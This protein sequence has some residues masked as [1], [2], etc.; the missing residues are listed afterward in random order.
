MM[1]LTWLL[2]VGAAHG[3]LPG[4]VPPEASVQVARLVVELG[5]TDAARQ[6]AAEEALLALGPDASGPLV[7]CVRGAPPARLRAIE[8]LLPRF[9]PAAV[10]RLVW[11]SERDYGHERE[12]VNAAI[13][14]VGRMGPPAIPALRA[15]LNRGHGIGFATQALGAMGPPG[16][17]EL[18]G[19]VSGPAPQVRARAL[20]ALASYPEA[21]SVPVFLTALESPDPE[22]RLQGLRGLGSL[23]LPAT[24]DAIG[25]RLADEN[26]GVREWAAAVVVKVLTPPLR[27]KLIE[28][29][30]DD[31]SVLV[32]KSAARGLM[33]V[34]GDP[35]AVRLG[36]RY[37]PRTT[38]EPETGGPRLAVALRLMLGGLLLYAAVWLGARRQTGAMG[39][40]DAPKAATAVALMGFYWGRLA[41]GV[42]GDVER[43]LLWICVPAVAWVLWFAGP[44]LRALLLPAAGLAASLAI[45]VVAPAL[46][47]IFTLW[48]FASAPAWLATALASGLAA[49]VWAGRDADP[50]ALRAFRRAAI[51]SLGA[52]YLGYSVGWWALW[53]LR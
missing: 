19:L 2:V 6:N 27:K 26:E 28:V 3:D 46:G 5:K 38:A 35:V 34:H 15:I 12:V 10:P 33:R 1:A 20:S 24:A 4:P 49:A 53:H 16:L 47:L 40:G 9:G 44:S 11:T 52:F 30:R 39:T 14:A 36:R 41:T 51:P 48:A 18:R 8:S 17:A 29:A 13:V 32:R 23:A 25:A 31:T 7:A 50:S 42:S 22:F 37:L 45:L 43:L 21:A